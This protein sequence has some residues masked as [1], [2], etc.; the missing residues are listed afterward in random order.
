M[1]N[2]VNLLDF[3]YDKMSWDTL[4][5]EGDDCTRLMNTGDLT[6][7]DKV[8]CEKTFKEIQKRTDIPEI[9]ILMESLLKILKYMQ[10]LTVMLLCVTSGGM[11]AEPHM[12]L[13]SLYLKWVA[14]KNRS[15]MACLITVSS[16]HKK[17]FKKQYE[18][19]TKELLDLLY[20]EGYTT[21]A[22]I[23]A[24]LNELAGKPVPTRPKLR[25]VK[26]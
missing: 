4:M 17:N 12:N 15:E 19:L 18:I 8:R 14:A 9:V 7:N 6:P 5:K 25:L 10:R 21:K 26:S 16:I 20:K 1:T 11:K 13:N 3:K 23:D 22:Q 24:K 2:V